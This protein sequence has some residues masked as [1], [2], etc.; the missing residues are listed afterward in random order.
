VCVEQFWHRGQGPLEF[1]KAM[2]IEKTALISLLEAFVDTSEV[3]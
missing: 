3:L 1:S 2:E